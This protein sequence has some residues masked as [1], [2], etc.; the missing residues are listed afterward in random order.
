MSNFYNNIGF[1]LASLENFEDKL[2][3]TQILKT[4]LATPE[5]LKPKTY[6]L[7]KGDKQIANVDEL[8]CAFIEPSDKTIDVKSVVICLDHED[9]SGY[10]ILWQKLYV[11]G[12]NG[13]TGRVNT[14]LLKQQ[15]HLLNDFYSLIKKL[16]RITKPVY[17]DCKNNA[18][19]GREG[20]NLALRL[21][22]IC[23]V[24]IFGPP[25]VE[26]FGKELIETAPYEYIEEIAPGYYW[27]QAN[28]SVFEPV[29]EAKK[30]A[31][32]EHFGE[33]A[34]GRKLKGKTGRAP[35]FDFRNTVISSTV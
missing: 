26:L 32:R 22:D 2:F 12:F 21:P 4:F 3:A 34:F 27:L 11:E 8:I 33:D 18:I 10:M 16:V 13:I 35:K 30:R 15:Q 1:T 14:N 20:I 25:Y 24:S 28:E 9:K 23:H 6:N 17:G 29:P 5:P 31:I 7:L 19:K